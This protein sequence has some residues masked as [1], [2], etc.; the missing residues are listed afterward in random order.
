MN[1]DPTTKPT[2]ETLLEMMREMRTEMRQGFAAMEKRFDMIDRKFDLLLKDVFQLRTEQVR[3][4][5]RLEKLER[6]RA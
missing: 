2:L 1:D 5:E 3:T 6:P 4:D